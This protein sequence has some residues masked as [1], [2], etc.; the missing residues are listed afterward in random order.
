VIPGDQVV[1]QAKIITHSINGYLL[2]YYPYAP[3]GKE[4]TELV[5]AL[6]SFIMRSLTYKEAPMQ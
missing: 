6:V 3:K 5:D 1:A 4:R 2:E